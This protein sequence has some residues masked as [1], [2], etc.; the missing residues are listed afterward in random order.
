MFLFVEG[1]FILDG[2]LIANETMEFLKKLKRKGLIFKV[3]FKKAYDNIE[4]GFL[5]EIMK[6]MGF[7][8]RLCKW[9]IVCLSSSSISILVNGSPT[10]EFVMERGV[11]QGDPLSP[12]HFI[13]A[14]KGLN[15][16]LKE[17]VNKNIFNG[18][19][20][21]ADGVMCFEVVVGLKINLHKSKLYGVGVETN[22]LERMA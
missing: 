22:E 11:R 18:V 21:G 2:V 19:R 4:W 8:D 5:L 12:F 7:G 10:K 17:V 14:V 13:L 3:D 20:V 9:V 15:A 6:C 1:R 16:L